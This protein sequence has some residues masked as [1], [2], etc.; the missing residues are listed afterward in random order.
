MQLVAKKYCNGCSACYSVCPKNAISMRFDK[1]GFLYPEINQNCINCGLCTKICPANKKKSASLFEKEYFA[2]VNNSDTERLSGSSGGIFCLI[3]KTVLEKGGVIFGAS[4][5]EDFSV[6]HKKATDIESLESLKTSKY[7]QSQLDD[8]F[9]QVLI[10][11]EKGTLVLFTGTPCQVAGLNAFLQKDYPNLIVQDLICHGAPSPKIWQN[12]LAKLQKKYNSGIE[13]VNFR[14][15]I[16]G[17]KNYRLTIKFKNGKIYS[18]SHS[19]DRFMNLFLQNRILR[20]SCHNCTF[21][22]DNRHSDI[23]LGDFWGGYLKKSAKEFNDN[24]G[25]SLIIVNSIKGKN[26]IDNLKNIKIKHVDG[27]KALKGNPSYFKKAL[28]NPFRKISL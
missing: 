4:F 28:L 10:E 18:V 25:C 12:Y 1:E 23:T 16:N 7:A 19:L 6:C 26:L 5:T 15:K 8:C 3:A 21:K 14:D 24:K 27:K 17:W 20:P 2:A 11:L 9:K 13:Y 22:G